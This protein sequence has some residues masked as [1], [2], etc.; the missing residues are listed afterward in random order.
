MVSGEFARGSN[1]YIKKLNT[2]LGAPESQSVLEPVVVEVGQ[3]EATG[4][5][6]DISEVPWDLIQP[7]TVDRAR[8]RLRAQLP[9]V[10]WDAAALEGNTFTLPEVRT[11]LDGVTVAGKRVEEAQQ[12]LALSDAFNE[13]DTLVGSGQFRLDKQTSDRLHELLA[14][15]EAIESGGFRGEGSAVGGGHVR[16]SN[17]TR[18]DG[19]DHGPGGR[20]LID[21]FDRL[22][23]F[24]AHESDP[25]IAALAYF[26]AATRSQFYFDGN[27]R[28]ARLMSAGHLMMNGFDA[29][30]VPAARRLEFNHALDR[31]FS[32][33]DATE[34]MALLATS[35]ID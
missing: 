14:R 35:A 6:W 28:T 34:V 15:H 22:T 3:F 17:G 30:S 5:T 19:I 32:T 7:S 31:L 24:V 12:I 2:N 25:R 8:A 16:L 18:V 33:D 29:V 13:L 10:V 9:T 23:E 27:K 20:L 21:R 11:L 4:V 1:Q 26:A